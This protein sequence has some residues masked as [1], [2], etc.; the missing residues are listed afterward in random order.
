M[1]L[2]RRLHMQNID[3]KVEYWKKKLLDLGKRNRLISCPEPKSGVSGGGRISRNALTI[4]K[5]DISDLW[6]QFSDGE[7][8][9]K[10]PMP[11]DSNKSNYFS[12]E[13]DENVVETDNDVLSSSSNTNQSIKETHTTLIN[14]RKKAKSFMEE[15]GL[16]ALYLAFG[17]L[18]WREQDKSEIEIRSPLVLVPVY[19]EQKDL[20]SPFMMY[21]HDDEIIANPALAQKLFLDFGVKLPEFTS[22]TNDIKKY[23]TDV[24]TICASKGWTVV[25]SVELSLFS[26]FKINMY[27]DVAE[28]SELIKANSI[29]Q[30][31]AGSSCVVTHDFDD[32]SDYDHDSV[33]P[34]DV[35]S[36]VDADSSQQDAI[37]LAKRGV[38][39]V[40]Q[41]PP[42]TGK[43]QT[44][45][46][47]I[48]ELLA[49]N[50]KVLFVSEKMAALDVVYKRLTRVGLGDFCLTLHSY[51]AKRNEVLD[52]I[53]KSL[54]LAE[55]KA[56]ITS[57]ATHKLENLNAHRSEL[58]QYVREVHTKIAPFGKTIYQI[59]GEIS[60][61]NDFPDMFFKLNNIDK[62]S[63]QEF[64]QQISL[65]EELSHFIK[66]HNWQT[67]NPW[68]GSSVAALTR[69]FSLSF[70]DNAK[71]L[72]LIVNESSK[73]LSEIKICP[74]TSKLLTYSDVANFVTNI[75]TVLGFIKSLLSE[76]TAEI[77]NI[78]YTTM[79]TRFEKDYKS[80]FRSFNKSY[81]SDKM[82][83]QSCSKSQNK[84]SD[85]KIKKLLHDLSFYSV[86]IKDL[87]QDFEKVITSSSTDV[88]NSFAK[89][90]KWLTHLNETIDY[91]TKLFELK[92]NDSNLNCEALNQRVEKCLKNMSALERWIEFRELLARCKNVG[93]EDYVKKIEQCMLSSE[94]IVPTFKK[95]F[96]ALLLESI[97]PRFQAVQS[98]RRYKQEEC[99]AKF[100][101][102]DSEFLSIA[103]ATLFAKLV[104]QLPPLRVFTP[105]RDELYLLKREMAKKR[106]CLSVRR[107]IGATSTLLPILKPCMLMSPLS[108]S[109]YL[110][111]A[112]YKF[113]VVI[114][115]E[116][117]QVRTEDA[118][119][120][121]FRSK[122]VIIAGDSKQLPPTD[123]FNVTSAYD[124]YL[125]EDA[126]DDSGAYESLLDEAALLPQQAL[127]WHY[128]SRH[129]HLIAFSNAKIYNNNL[130]TFP[131]STEKTDSNSG[132]EYVFVEGGT[133]DRGK[134]NGNRK[135]AQRVA[136][137]VFEHFKKLPHRSLG[138]IAFGEI[139]QRAIET[140]VLEMRR[141]NP[142]Y[143]TFFGDDKEEP[144]FIKNLE[145]V[146]GDERDNI[147]FCI[148]YAPDVSGKFIMNFGPLSRIGGELRLNVAITRA[149]YNVKLVGSILPTDI[150]VERVS[151]EGPKLLRLYIDFAI[152]GLSA[153]M[154]E[155]SVSKSVWHDSHFEEVVYT[156]LKSR[157]Y[158]VVAQVGCSGYRI[159]MAVRHPKYTGCYAIGVECD[160]ASYHSARTA[161]DRDR[162]RQSILEQMGWKIYRV[163]STDWIKNSA[164]EGERLIK[165]V[166]LAIK[167]YR[168]NSP[169][170]KAQMVHEKT[171]SPDYLTMVDKPETQIYRP[172]YYGCNADRIPV[173][174]FG[175][176][177]LRTL[178]Q[179]YGEIV[180]DDLLL[181]TSMAYGWK[182]R[183][184]VINECL[185]RAYNKLLATKEIKENNGKVSL[186]KS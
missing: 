12:D 179:C 54:K 55:S 146:Q 162:L 89:I 28:N 58:N 84:L 172:R 27:R 102:L 173:D 26:F 69:D 129:E 44:I 128:R 53:G 29:I 34:I 138:V 4:L 67:T 25:P 30:A 130:I 75:H 134:H 132:V 111:G 19:L 142:E 91:F 24:T 14:L 118:I 74:D 2:L 120:A 78:D 144:L 116:A 94:K 166:D 10:F 50:K 41:G 51:K 80:I 63:E 115:D 127:L 154:G 140:A 90:S 31:L 182:R 3:A 71:E 59:N 147:I 181:A 143:E 156:F 7:K 103:R 157:N 22:N 32:V 16:N 97:L 99:V 117:S 167:N 113:D 168:E 66:E 61:L 21:R 106:M 45:T 125:D 108:V 11:I 15:K 164:E 183:G 169:K 52:Q 68:Y 72:P 57:D 186:Y 104:S 124:E 76:Y 100:R 42:G 33:K 121:I 123:F 1:L 43:S 73:I 114:F 62:C 155:P 175:K 148:G 81:K 170:N 107:L 9:F 184:N 92:T 60:T 159:D 177:M 153:I 105:G 36:V 110:G 160:G 87:G 5:P 141:H 20:F 119:G 98:F 23:L 145:T 178:S 35:F 18:K 8:P 77:F 48:A 46:N 38:S 109:T 112:D 163:W 151:G 161:R 70:I 93:I 17:F 158:D 13:C 37:L 6:K 174:E 165:A 126:V 49:N 79:L 133:Y 85:D 96:Y 180:K 135:E 82:K 150:D 171:V 185:E 101:E 176:T 136:E 137:L 122:Q 149:R 64:E 86:K 152:N 95:S 65:L 39:F 131:S 88:I 47:M 139:Q 83:I 56:Y 40:L